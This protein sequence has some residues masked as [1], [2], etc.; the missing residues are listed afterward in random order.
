MRAR[1][2]DIRMATSDDLPAMIRVQLHSV[3]AAYP[4]P[5]RALLVANPQ[6]VVEE[7]SRRWSEG[8]VFVVAR[9][10]ERLVGFAAASV[11][12]SR[13]ELVALFVEPEL[14]R[15]GIG[16]ALTDFIARRMS[17]IGVDRLSVLANPLVE[18]FY[19]AAGFVPD[20]LVQI[21][22][23]GLVPRFLRAL[24]RKCPA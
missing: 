12:V 24:D 5:I 2:I 13:A 3:T 15:G 9:R 22:N 17:A 6:I 21:P 16:T 23:F 20:E 8:D 1:D 19:T 18:G 7:V 11:N 4:D 14:W 10:G